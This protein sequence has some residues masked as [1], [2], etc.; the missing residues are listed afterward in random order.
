MN[1]AVRFPGSLCYAELGTVIKDSGGEY[2]YL[3]F[4][5]APFVPY[6]FAWVNNI[7]IKPASLG[8]ITLTC[9]EYIT[10]PMFDDGCGGAPVYLKKII[11]ILVLRKFILARSC[12]F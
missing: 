8:L 11:A 6:I 5:Y 10:A 9:A 12:I 1:N 7:L 4:A 2:S 3:N